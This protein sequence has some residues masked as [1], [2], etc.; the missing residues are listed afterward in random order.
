MDLFDEYT[1]K[2]IR[3]RRFRTATLVIAIA[4]IIILFFFI[5]KP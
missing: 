3:K 5:V 1:E 2:V 4:G